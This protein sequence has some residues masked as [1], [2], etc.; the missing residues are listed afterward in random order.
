MT[1]STVNWH[2]LINRTELA[3][4]GPVSTVLAGQTDAG[5]FGITMEPRVDLEHDHAER[6]VQSLL[7]MQSNN[8]IQ[9]ADYFQS[10]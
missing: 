7:I 5:G 10:A 4:R 8:E 3:S 9:P 1:R 6:N 2:R